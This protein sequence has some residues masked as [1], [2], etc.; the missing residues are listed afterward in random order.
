MLFRLDNDHSSLVKDYGLWIE[1][2]NRFAAV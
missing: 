2:M 1:G